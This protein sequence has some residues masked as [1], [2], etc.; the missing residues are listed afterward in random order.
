LKRKRGPAREQ[1]DQPQEPQEHT[2]VSNDIEQRTPTPRTWNLA[3]Q[4]V[5]HPQDLQEPT[6]HSG[7][8]EHTPR[9]WNPTSESEMHSLVEATEIAPDFDQYASDL[10][11]VLTP[12]W[13]PNSMLPLPSNGL[14]AAEDGMVAN[15]PSY[16]THLPTP[17]L[18]DE[19]HSNSVFQ[20]MEFG[21]T[22]NAAPFNSSSHPEAIDFPP[23][24]SAHELFLRKG[25]SGSKFIGMG[26]VGST[27]L[28]CLRYSVS[29]HSGSIEST[30]LD[31][32]VHGIRHV[33]ELAL[34]ATFDCPP[35]PERD[36]AERGVQAYYDFLHL[37]YPI[38]EV[39]FLHQWH[40]FYDDSNYTITPTSYSRLCLVVSIGNIISPSRADINTLEIAQR[41]QEKAWGL[42]DRV[43]ASPFMESLQVTLLHTIFLL[44]CGKTGIAWTTCG[45]A[46]RVAQSLGLHQHTP[47]QLGLSAENVS[48]RARLWSVAYSL[49]A[50][51]SLSEGRPS[52]ITGSLNLGVSYRLSEQECTS[53]P[54]KSPAVFIHD[55]DIGLAVIANE[56]LTLLKNSKSLATTLAQIAEIDTELLAWKDAIPMEF[57]PDQEIFA[58]DPFYSLVAILHLK[59]HNLMRTIHWISL[60]LSSDV[61]DL[62]RLGARVRSS[63]NI[64][65]TSSR[66]V[67]EVLNGM[68][69]QRIAGS[70]GAFIVPYCMAAISVF[71]RQILKE[72]TRPGTRTNLEH[73]RN[74]TVHIT[75]LLDSGIGSRRHFRTLFE[76]MLRV[77]EDVVQKTV[78]L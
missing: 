59:Y 11:L 2:Q 78:V 75:T 16:S 25:P 49:D 54:T 77:A 21:Q 65:V 52:S 51:L 31:H 72:P 22:V 35:L 44:C 12:F 8:I 38:M 62:S 53:L 24:R 45:M 67:I 23:S 73:M 17:R 18:S 68:S 47:I 50:F 34:S 41:L 57:R 32:L 28:E 4:H 13:P 43:L 6:Q 10:G 30:V 9:V 58:E 74:G 15:M 48:L 1:V 69:S 60:T 56:V 61:M 40:Q 55:W 66:S 37:L 19:T 70:P 39:D 7:D 3:N 36:F 20:S 14:G 63:E 64:C 71:Y 27:I 33:D 76:V 5:N 42:I 26:S 46:V 29:A